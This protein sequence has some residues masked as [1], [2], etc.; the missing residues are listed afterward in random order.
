M[1]FLERDIASKATN[2]SHIS[3]M[4]TKIIIYT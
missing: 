4:P 3:E 2:E 1:F